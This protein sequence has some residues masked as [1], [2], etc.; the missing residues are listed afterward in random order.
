MTTE[1][2]RYVRSLKVYESSHSNSKAV[3]NLSG[4]TCVNKTDSFGHLFACHVSENSYSGYETGFNTKAQKAHLRFEIQIMRYEMRDLRF[5]IR[6]SISKF[7]NQI[8]DLKTCILAI[9]NCSK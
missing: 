5:E 2:R 4:I 7:T 6:D 3:R 9:S 8:K 1:I